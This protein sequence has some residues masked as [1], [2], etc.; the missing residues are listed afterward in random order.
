M[1]NRWFHCIWP[2]VFY[3]LCVWAAGMSSGGTRWK[4]SKKVDYQETPTI[5]CI[6]A[7]KY[8][9]REKY[10]N[11]LREICTT[12]CVCVCV[13]FHCFFYTS[14]RLPPTH[15]LPLPPIGLPEGVITWPLTPLWTTA[16]H[17]S[18]KKKKR[19]K[20]THLLS[21]IQIIH[22]ILLLSCQIKK[23]YGGSLLGF[24]SLQKKKGYIET[25]KEYRQKQLIQADPT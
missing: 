9:R 6:T 17:C 22:T 21:S 20:K 2:H 12:T 7:Y 1:S 24:F 25:L 18:L 14:L 23:I 10:Q 19:K 8:G 4:D 16:R 5:A 11:K 3:S 13:F 15:T